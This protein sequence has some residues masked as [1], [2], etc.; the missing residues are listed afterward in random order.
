[1]SKFI[2]TW[3]AGSEDGPKNIENYRIF[4]NEHDA[5]LLKESF[6]DGNSPCIDKKSIKIKEI[7]W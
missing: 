2:V 5:K 3:K 1:M 7:K 4:E 6:E